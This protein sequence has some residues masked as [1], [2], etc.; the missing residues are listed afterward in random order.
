MQTSRRLPGVQDLP[1]CLKAQGRGELGA[2]SPQKE[3]EGRGTEPGCV[4]RGRCGFLSQNATGRGEGLPWL[5][6]WRKRRKRI[7]Q[8]QGTPA[9]CSPHRLCSQA[10]LLIRS[11]RIVIPRACCLEQCFPKSLSRDTLNSLPSCASSPLL[12]WLLS[13]QGH[14]VGCCGHTDQTHSGCPPGP[15]V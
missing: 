1:C 3:A 10:N 5:W 15:A 2:C 13:T 4:C 12:S 9:H 7:R 8:R 6:R 11:E 14:R